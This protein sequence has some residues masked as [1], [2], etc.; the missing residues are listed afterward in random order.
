MAAADAQRNADSI[1]TLKDAAGTEQFA[2]NNNGVEGVNTDAVQAASGGVVEGMGADQISAV[3][4]GQAGIEA[5]AA[6]RA[7]KAAQGVDKAEAA[8]TELAKAQLST[9]KTMSGS[10]VGKGYGASASSRMTQSLSRVADNKAGSASI[11]QQAA[12]GLP[13][14]NTAADAFKSGRAGEIGGYNVKAQGDKAG[15]NGQAFF[16]TTVAELSNAARYSQAGKKTVYGDSGKGTALA[17]A[18]FDGSETAAEGVKIEG[19]N[20]QQGATQA[21]EGTANTLGMKPKNNIGSLDI[22][23]DGV[24]LG[25]TLRSKILTKIILMLLAGVVAAAATQILAN[26]AADAVVAWPLWIAAGATCLAGILGATFFMWGGSSGIMDLV[27]EVNGLKYGGG[28]GILGTLGPIVYGL[29]VGGVGASIIPHSWKVVKNAI[30]KAYKW[31]VNGVKS[32]GKT[33]GGLLGI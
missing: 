4:G 12:E 10:S 26:L 8:S 3:A 29:V 9:S 5:A 24:K 11:P 15:T 20:V 7:A 16:S 32:L 21:L 22:V 33:L 18:A 19:L 17:Q 23:D 1:Y 13:G 14:A 6:E 27:E 31:M 28:A 30:T 2:Y 25:E